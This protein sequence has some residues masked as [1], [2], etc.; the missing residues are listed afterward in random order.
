[1]H[2]DQLTSGDWTI[3]N[4]LL[5]VGNHYNATATIDSE[6]N[7]L[8]HRGCPPDDTGWTPA[9]DD[10]LSAILARTV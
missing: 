9:N 4:A 10:D 8:I 6:G 7:V 1:M 3:G 5:A 2:I